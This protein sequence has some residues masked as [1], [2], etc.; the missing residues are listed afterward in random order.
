MMTNTIAI[1]EKALYN[2]LIDI[3]SH[4]KQANDWLAN[5][6]NWLAHI[7]DKQRYAHAP[8]YASVIDKL[9]KVAP[10]SVDLNAKNITAVIPFDHADFKKTQALIKNL[11]PWRK[12]G[13]VIGQH[14][15]SI[16]IDTEWRSDLKWDR[17]VP[18]ISDLTGRRVLDVGGG[19]GYHG[20][21]MVGA[22]AKPSWSL[23]H[24]VYFII[25]LCWFVI[26]LAI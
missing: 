25:S 22:G 1:A 15:K 16:H 14:D 11:M 20:F 6:P 26:L 9:P 17:I 23:T 21:R 12:G 3:S 18:F 5:L 4:D 19:S 10:L 7:K 8:Y 24:L 2:T 13:F